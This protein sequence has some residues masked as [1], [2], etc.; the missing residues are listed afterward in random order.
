[1][2]ALVPASADPVGVAAT[3]DVV[4]EVRGLA[5]AYPGRPPVEAVRDVSFALRAGE[6]IA[7]VGESG[8]GKSTLAAALIGL[9]PS[10]GRV[11]RGTLSLD[12]RALHELDERGWRGIRG[13][14]IGMVFQEAATALDP[15]MTVGGHLRETL[16]V[17]RR[18][19]GRAA[20]REALEL[21]R[22]VGL[23]DPER[24]LRQYPHELSGGM[25]QRVQ[26][27]VA[28][29]GDPAI[30]VADEP[31]TALDVTV[32]AQILALLR[33]RQRERGMSLVL[34]S[35][36]LPVVASVVDRVVI[37]YGGRVMESGETRR[38]FAAPRHPYTAALLR[39]NP[40]VD[41]DIEIRPIPG[42]PPR[43][44][45]VLPGCPFAA[46]CGF[47]LAGCREAPPRLAVVDDRELA[48]PVDP[49]RAR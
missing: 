15:L 13:R 44:A 12:G 22:E 4:L 47:A 7:L 39:A 36:A 43:A 46:R 2:S 21:V 45:D 18:V 8:S 23:S 34:V 30:L 6:A 14:R 40:D 37:L 3:G 1:V 9:L 49:L 27:A 16:R 33:Q 5:I 25:R 35:H 48:C 26:I 20:A 28:L 29:A 19:G 24:R 42:T 10:G 31:T 41:R 32:Q 38:L 11:V 17:T